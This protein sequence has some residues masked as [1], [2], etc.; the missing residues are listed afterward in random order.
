MPNVRK[1]S[2][3]VVSKQSPPC[4]PC[5]FMPDMLKYKNTKEYFRDLDLRMERA[6]IS[7][8]D[9]AAESGFTHNAIS[10]WRNAHVK[11]PQFD[12]ILKLEHAFHRLVKKKRK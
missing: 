1:P 10:R 11:S 8:Y 12:N 2:K 3:Q 5:A 4:S 6:G 9:L 7:Q